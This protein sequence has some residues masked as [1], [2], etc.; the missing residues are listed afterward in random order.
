MDK[1]PNLTTEL[2]SGNSGMKDILGFEIDQR[3]LKYIDRSKIRVPAFDLSRKDDEEYCKH[4]WQ[5]HAKAILYLYQF[6]KREK[7]KIPRKLKKGYK[8]FHWSKKAMT[9]R[10]DWLEYLQKEDKLTN[11]DRK[12]LKT[13]YKRFN[14]PYPMTKWAKR[15]VIVMPRIFMQG[16]DKSLKGLEKAMALM[17]KNK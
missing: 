14:K 13:I 12:D 4:V 15:A 10:R 5:E 9:N 16:L 1:E 11:E 8:G 2:H 3:K 6:R 17:D 7:T